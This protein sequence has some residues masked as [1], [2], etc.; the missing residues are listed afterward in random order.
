MPDY[1][2]YL[3]L[4]YCICY[5]VTLASFNYIFIIVLESEIDLPEQL[6]V[7]AFNYA[8]CWDC[9]TAFVEIQTLLFV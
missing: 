8:Y 5:V 6:G 3:D 1:L 9:H 4:R 2:S 7:I